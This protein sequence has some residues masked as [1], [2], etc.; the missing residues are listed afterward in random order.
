M[1]RRSLLTL[2]VLAGTCKLGLAAEP[3]KQDAIDLVTK[4]GAYLKANGK[5]KLVEALNKT[6]GDFHKGELYVMAYDL[7]G[8]M[9]AHPVNAKLIG[10]N[11][12]DVPD[13]DGKFFRK[14]IVETAKG[15]GTGWV[16][17]KYKNPTNNK[18]EAKT[19]YVQAA[20]DLILAAGI[21]KN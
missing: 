3:T 19:T 12:V 5:A 7:T 18:V 17:Y 6:N 20:G 10:R 1:N 16:D 4:A 11:M 2:A 9:V 13:P 15:K 21:Y 8:T 14:D